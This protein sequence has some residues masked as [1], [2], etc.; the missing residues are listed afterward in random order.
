MGAK[1]LSKCLEMLIVA[2]MFA[3]F[4]HGTRLSVS[5]AARVLDARYVP[6]QFVPF[7]KLWKVTEG[8][9]RGMR[10]KKK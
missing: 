4:D 7:R 10:A 8:K 3:P 1:A 2:S 5:T 9:K 6:E